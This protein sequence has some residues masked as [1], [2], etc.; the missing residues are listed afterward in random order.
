MGSCTFSFDR[1][2]QAGGVNV[3]VIVVE[4]SVETN[5]V[6]AEAADRVGDHACGGA[7]RVLAGGGTGA[8]LGTWV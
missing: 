6:N 1:I 2:F 7:V 5:R 4:T 8:E 3:A